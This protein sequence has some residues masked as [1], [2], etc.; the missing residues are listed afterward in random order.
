MPPI[1]RTK[2]SLPDVLA[3]NIVLFVVKYFKE[4]LTVCFL[5]EPKY[6]YFCHK[7]RERDDYGTNVRTGESAAQIG[8]TQETDL[9]NSDR[10]PLPDVLG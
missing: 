6:Y 3:K 10:F 9:K 1:S 8:V 5:H 7:L 2:V 4:W